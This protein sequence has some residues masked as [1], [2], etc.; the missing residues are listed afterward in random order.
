MF[1]AADRLRRRAERLIG[2][3]RVPLHHPLRLPATEGHQQFK[4]APGPDANPSLL[5]LRVSRRSLAVAPADHVRM[6]D[7]EAWAATQLLF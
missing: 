7:R 1:A 2:D 5:L 6:V 4:R 3:R